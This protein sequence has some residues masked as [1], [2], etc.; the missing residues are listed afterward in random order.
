MS[1]CTQRCID[2]GESAASGSRARFHTCFLADSFAVC[3][4]YNTAVCSRILRTYLKCARSLPFDIGKHIAG[5]LLPPI[6]FGIFGCY[7]QQMLGCILLMY[8]ESLGLDSDFRNKCDGEFR[9]SKLH[10]DVGFPSVEGAD[11]KTP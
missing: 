4:A 3:I 2:S 7:R 5:L 9:C 8:G 6:A 10:I 11:E 1:F